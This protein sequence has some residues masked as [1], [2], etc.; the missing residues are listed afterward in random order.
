ME[1]PCLA[2]KKEIKQLKDWKTASIHD[3]SEPTEIFP[4]IAKIWLTRP[5]TTG[6]GAGTING[7][8]TFKEYSIDLYF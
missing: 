1:L 7:N 8:T 4:C 5:S 6:V 2:S 3:Q